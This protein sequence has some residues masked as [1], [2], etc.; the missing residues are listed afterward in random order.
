MGI[1]THN[2]ITFVFLFIALSVISC[3]GQE[4]SKKQYYEK[5][6]YFFKSGNPNGAIVAFK[7]AIEKDPEYYEA[8]YQ[9]SQAYT[10]QDKYESAQ[11]E[12]R[13][14]LKLNPSFNEAHLSLGKIFLNRGEV[15]DAIEE[16]NL[17]LK[18]IDVSRKNIIK[19]C[20]GRC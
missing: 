8:R 4:L 14:V 10:L 13:K 2:F 1:L 6:L 12:L 7:K 19:D 11:K 18:N 16:I 3:N 9:L 15:D 5:G 17:Y 20:A